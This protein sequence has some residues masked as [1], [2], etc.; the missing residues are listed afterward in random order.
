LTVINELQCRFLAILKERKREIYLKTIG[1]TVSSA[2]K[3]D[4]IR[5]GES[6]VIFFAI[7]LEKDKKIVTLYLGRR[8]HQH[9]LDVDN[10]DNGARS[11]ATRDQCHDHKFGNFLK[12]VRND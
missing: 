11:P 4:V 2:E 8:S 1:W 10:M 12:T 9:A 6:A 3:A 5:V 7:F